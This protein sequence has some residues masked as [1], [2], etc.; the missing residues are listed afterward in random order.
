MWH[1]GQE[2]KAETRVP[3]GF[4]SEVLPGTR[5]PCALREDDTASDLRSDG[6]ER[7]RGKCVCSGTGSLAP[8][9]SL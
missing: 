5:Q 6:Q 3:K 8:R 4:G 1:D 7:D 2:V 9:V